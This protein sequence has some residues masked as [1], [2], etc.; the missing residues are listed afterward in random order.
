MGEEFRFWVPR[1]LEDVGI[2]PS[3]RLRDPILLLTS[4]Q[5]EKD[6]LFDLRKPQA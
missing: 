3:I 2:L 1:A 5:A 4:L 6:A